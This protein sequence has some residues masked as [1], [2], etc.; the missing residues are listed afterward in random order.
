MQTA[1][2]KNTLALL[3]SKLV[4]S[5]LLTL[6]NVLF[7]RFL[8]QNE[9]GIY[10]TVWT[11]LS[12]FVIISTFG[13]PRYILT[14]GS[15]FH[16]S[17]GMIFRLIALVFLITIVPL[18]FYLI[19][20]D[21]VFSNWTIFLFILLLISQSIYLIQEANVLSLTANKL[22]IV[23]NVSYAILLFA[24]HLLL[25]FIGYS[26]DLCLMMIIGVSFIRNVIIFLSV[27]NQFTSEQ[28]LP[29]FK[30]R[31]QLLWFG[32]NDTLQILTKWID[33]I[34]LVLI[35]PS[36][37]YAIYFNGTYEIPLI[38][39]GLSAFQAILTTQSAKADSTE[40]TNLALFNTAAMFMSGILF[41]LFAFCVLFADEIIFILFGSKYV[42]SASLFAITALLI[43]MRICNYTVLLQ[44]KSRGDII[45]IGS[46][47]DFAVAITL[48]IFLYPIG[49]L[50]GLA[51]SIVIA[52]YI[53]AAFYLFKISTIYKTRLNILL[54]LK[55]LAIRFV[56]V[57]GTF[58]VAKFA[59]DQFSG[60]I[61]LSV[62]ALVF[63]VFV[64]VF[65]KKSID[66]K[67]LLPF[68]S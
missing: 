41:P 65:L 64:L 17:K 10:Q 26:I 61:S 57:L 36:A 11:Y 48:M 33:K 44:L 30:E 58:L 39:M 43:P 45:L 37:E 16:Y 14:Y 66:F 54:P 46:L 63:E 27:K 42:E 3:I 59:L 18:T 12:I 9:Y 60:V 35:L 47:I 5:L 51:L 38:G 56:I 50:N 62:G 52:T 2:L 31:L 53:Q 20:F 4:P 13:L 49:G 1:I 28:L 23:S 22:L 24:G 34:V 25:L 67:K 55:Q 32:V 15:L 21:S 29:A 8:S 6:I 7:S 40:V 68:R 19:F